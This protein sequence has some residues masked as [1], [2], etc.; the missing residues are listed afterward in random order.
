MVVD[1]KFGSFEIVKNHKEAFDIIKF[2]EKYIEECF[3]KYPYIV[4][5]ISS[6]KLRLKGFVLDKNKS[7]Y[8]KYIKEYIIESCGFNYPY[9]VLKRIGKV[10]IN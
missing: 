8:Y 7:N 4:G 1:T 5:D 2:E 6:E 10:E 3:D 9:Y